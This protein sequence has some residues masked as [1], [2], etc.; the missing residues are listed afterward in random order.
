[1]ADTSDGS[2][3]T[4]RPRRRVR[5][6]V[7]REGRLTRGQRRALDR[8]RPVYGLPAEGGPIDLDAV[9]GRTAERVLEIGFGDGETLAELARRHPQ[10]DFLGIEVHRPGI[11]RL[12]RRLA[13]LELDNVR[14][15]EG[16]AADVLDARIPEA[17][18][19]RIN[20]FF[21]DPWPKKRH[22]KRRLIQPGFAALAASRLAPE[23]ILHICTDWAD[24]AEQ[25]LA[26]LDAEPRLANTAGQGFA[27]R[28]AERPATKF[29]LR[30]A[31]RGH[32][33]RDI[34][35]SRRA[36]AGR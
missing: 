2:A 24:Y 1:M 14:V 16:D 9:F 27:R 7:R 30:G 18:L 32:E 15:I 19:A 12:L 13:E 29:E 36:G 6:F 8:Y 28:P 23:G 35:F 4:A 10:R 5:S 21:P 33:V 20:I 17:S 11:G 31:A 22:H 34:I 25:I 3:E 26:V